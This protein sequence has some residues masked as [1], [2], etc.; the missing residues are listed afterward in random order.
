MTFSSFKSLYVRLI[1]D[2]GV[3]KTSEYSGVCCDRSQS[4]VHNIKRFF[5]PLPLSY[6]IFL[7]LVHK[8][9][10]HPCVKSCTEVM[11]SFIQVLLKLYKYQ[12]K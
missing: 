3:T 8:T 7:H 1:I 6:D 5:C 9:P 10:I 2:C 12:L 11:F 4:F